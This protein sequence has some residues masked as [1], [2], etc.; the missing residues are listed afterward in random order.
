MKLVSEK[1][2][3]RLEKSKKEFKE[4]VGE[5]LNVFG[6]KTKEIK[7]QERIQKEKEEKRIQEEKELKRIKKELKKMPE[8]DSDREALTNKSKKLLDNKYLYRKEKVLKNLKQDKS[9]II[10]F[11]SLIYLGLFIAVISLS[12][13]HYKLAAI[14][15]FLVEL[16]GIPSI[17]FLILLIYLKYLNMTLSEFMNSFSKKM[18]DSGL[19]FLKVFFVGFLLFIII[20]VSIVMISVNN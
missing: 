12:L 3:K 19:F 13:T 18:D 9:L 17:V 6:I 7:E 11:L 16:I 2:K 14:I 20:M 10:A 4:D 8:N 5:L 15:V 1:D